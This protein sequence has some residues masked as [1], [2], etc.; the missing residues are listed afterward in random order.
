MQY[1]QWLFLS[2]I[3][4]LLVPNLTISTFQYSLMIMKAGYFFLLAL[5]PPALSFSTTK[6]VEWFPQSLIKLR[7]AWTGPCKTLYDDFVDKGQGQCGPVLNCLLGHGTSELR[8]TTMASAQVTLG[9]IPSL[10][11]CV[12]NSV[13][14]ISLVASQRPILTLFLTLGAPGM[15]PTRVTEYVNPFDVL[16]E[17]AFRNTFSG[18]KGAKQRSAVILVQY[19]LAL[20]ITANNLESSL[21]LGSRS[22]LSWGCRSWYMPMI[23]V[24][25]SIST[26]AFAAMSCNILKRNALHMNSED[27]YRWMRWDP[28]EHFFSTCLR[29]VQTCLC[30]PYVWREQ[31]PSI[32]VMVWQASA[33][34]LALAHTILGTLIL[35]SLI[36]VGF[37][38]TLVILARFLISALVS[39]IIVLLQLDMIK[40]QINDASALNGIG[41]SLKD[42]SRSADVSLEHVVG[43][44]DSATPSRC[45]E[46]V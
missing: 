38:D 27:L 2:N 8:K 18:A 16:D 22:V 30:V 24:F 39:R 29:S 36:F 11:T 35:S 37:H 33:S 7:K 46:T 32:K 34:C 43:S 14:E 12:G 5:F 1:L 40:A 25:F 3:H 45:F 28:I 20:A 6:F 42:S 19:L 15:Y 4:L 9:L 26:Y 10:L 44:N 23:W 17:A 41:G 31:T 21:R 13:P